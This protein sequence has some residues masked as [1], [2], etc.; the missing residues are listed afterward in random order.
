MEM[1]FF[2][3]FSFLKGNECLHSNPQRPSAL[4]LQ[5]AGWQGLQHAPHC[6]KGKK[7]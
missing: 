3:V 2:S 1:L 6:V 4:G 5:A 7:L